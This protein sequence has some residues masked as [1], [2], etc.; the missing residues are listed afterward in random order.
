MAPEEIPED[1]VEEVQAI[2]LGQKSWVTR[3][4]A[5]KE[6]A[7]TRHPL[8]SLWNWKAVGKWVEG[9]WIYSDTGIG[10]FGHLPHLF[11]SGP[12]IAYLYWKRYEYTLDQEW[13]RT[14]AYPMLKGVTEFYRNFPNLKKRMMESTTYIF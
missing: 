8:V 14:V 4:P 13:L 9:K 1:L 6:F 5:F 10:P 11:E 12:K 7:E 2:Y 3:S